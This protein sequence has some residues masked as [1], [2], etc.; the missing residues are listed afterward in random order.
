MTGCAVCVPVWLADCGC[1]CKALTGGGVLAIGRESAVYAVD[2][3][4]LV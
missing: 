3:Y 2:L 4:R 1:L